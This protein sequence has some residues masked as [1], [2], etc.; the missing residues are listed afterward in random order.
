M[1]KI[2]PDIKSYFLDK[3]KRFGATPRGADWKNQEAQEKRFEQILKIIDGSSGPFT[4]SDLGCGYGA[5]F[6]FIN[7]KCHRRFDYHGYDLLREMVELGKKL[8]GRKK[9]FHIQRIQNFAAMKQTDYTVA[10]GIFNFRNGFSNKFWKKYILTVLDQ[11]NRA[12]LK[13][14]S[15]NIL[16]IYSDRAFR[17]NDLYYAD[18]KFFFDYC[19]RKF[20]PHV[21]LVH[22]YGM[23]EFTILLFKQPN[24]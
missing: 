23:Y 6:G 3:V 8:Y 1:R 2:F 10:S 4:I 16:S 20:S 7:K 12:S 9:N 11:M 19:K 21:T 18:P 15:F 14:F 5:L 24:R 17:R 22:S 13:G